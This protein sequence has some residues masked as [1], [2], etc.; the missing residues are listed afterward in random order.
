MKSN[1]LIKQL[2]KNLSDIQV[3]YVKLHNYHWNVQGKHFFGIHNLTEE[4]YNYFAEQYDEFAERILQINGKPLT[5]LKSYLENSAI[6]EED[7]NEFSADDVLTGIIKD[8][9]YL[10]DELK[11]TAAISEEDSATQA[12]A[13]DNIAW[14]EKAIWMLNSSK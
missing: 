4:Y 7:K 2:N 11:K 8:F 10:K 9:E 1:K 6:K 5:T 13:E 14:L 12:L 3:L